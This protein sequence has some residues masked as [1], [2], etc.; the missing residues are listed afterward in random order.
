MRFWIWLIL[1]LPCTL[2]FSEENEEL[3][4]SS[5]EQIAGFSLDTNTLVSPLTGQLS[6]AETDLIARGAQNVALRRVY[7]PPHLPSPIGDRPV[8]EEYL[9]AKYILK[10]YKGW[11][12]APHAR[13][14]FFPENHVVRLTDP[15]GITLDFSVKDSET[16]ILSP[17]FGMSNLSGDRPGGEYDLRNTQITFA[18]NKRKIV[19]R[20]PDGIIR[21]YQC[22]AKVFSKLVYSLEKE[23]L[24]H[25]KLLRYHYKNGYL[26]QVASMDVE[27]RH[28]YAS[29]DLD[30][31]DS[32]INF[33]T[34][35]GQTAFYRYDIKK[36]KI[37]I[38][39][40]REGVKATKILPPLLTKV[41]SPFY[42]NEGI[43][44]SSK[45][46]LEEM[47]GKEHIFQCTHK[48]FQA[49]KIPSHL[50]I[51]QLKL[52]TG[53]D[54]T[55][56]KVYE[57]DYDLPRPG[58][59]AGMT[60][61]KNSDGRET[62]YHF[63][64]DLF[65]ERVEHK[66]KEGK[67]EKEKIYHFRDTPDHWLDFLAIRNQTG[68]CVY[69]KHFT[70]DEFGNPYTESFIGDLEGA[71][72]E[73]N[74][75]I[76][77]H[78]SK[79]GM[80]LLLKEDHED[81]RSYYYDY[82]PG[83]N[84]V[85]A[86]LLLVQEKIYTRE[87]YE[88]DDCNNLIKTIR[89]DGSSLDKN[90]LTD[91]TERLIT[92][93]TLKQEPPFLHLPEWIE[94]R[95]LNGMLKKTHL[96]YD[97]HG[98]VSQKDIYDAN[99]EFAYSLKFTYNERGD[100]MTQPN[101]LGDW[102][103]FN[104][105][106]RGRKEFESSF[107]GRLIKTTTHDLKGRVREVKETG[108]TIARTTT[109]EHDPY[110]NLIKKEDPFGN[111]TK[112]TPDSAAKKPARI[113]HPSISS[114][115]VTE[116]FTYDTFGRE[117]S[118][119]DPRGHTITTR[120]NFYD[121]PTHIQYPDGSSESFR[122]YKNGKLKS[123]EDR[124]GL[125]I[126]YT[127]DPLWRVETKTFLSKEKKEIAKET[128][129]YSSFHL[130]TFTDKEGHVT[131][132]EYDTAGRKI[133][134]TTEERITTFH[135]DSLGRVSEIHADPLITHLAYDFCNQVIEKKETDLKGNLLYKI[136]YSYDKDGNLETDTCYVHN[137]KSIEV[138]LYDP[139]GREIEHRDPLGFTAKTTYNEKESQLQITKTDPRGFATIKTYDAHNN[140][141]E[142]K[143]PLGVTELSYDPCSNLL[144]R[145]DQPQDGAAQTIRYTYTPTNQVET[146]TRAAGTEH[147]RITSYTYTPSGKV[148]T[149]TLPSGIVLRFDY[150]PLGFLKE[151]TS[152]DKTIHHTFTYNRLGDLLE[153][154]DHINSI[155]VERTPDPFGNILLENFSTG[156]SL[157][158]TYDRFNRP[159]TL[160]LGTG[161][162][163]RY[164][165][166]PKHLR[167]IERFSSS[168]EL[169]YTHVYEEYD[170]A[171]NIIQEDLIGSLGKRVYKYDPA[172]RT[173]KLIS[174]YFSQEFSYDE[175]GNPKEI[176]KNGILHEY[177]YDALS[178]ISSEPNH[179][180]HHNALY[181]R[182]EK[183]GEEIAI[184]PLNELE[185]YSY[186]LDGNMTTKGDLTFSY[187]ALNRLKMVHCDDLTITFFYDPLGRRLIK[188]LS[189]RS[190]GEKHPVETEHYLYDGE[191]E[192]GAFT[193]DHRQKNL[194]ISTIAIELEEKPFAP[195]LDAHNNI[196]G[197]IDPATQTIAATYTFTTFGEKLLTDELIFN[198]W[199]YASKR[200]DPETGLI[201]FGKRYYD[202][203]LARW[204]TIDPAG[205]ID[206]V[207]FYQYVYNNPF[208]YTD[209]NGEFAIPLFIWAIGTSLPS[210]SAIITPIIYGA[211]TGAVL[212]TGYK[213]VDYAN[214]HDANYSPA[215][216]YADFIRKSELADEKKGKKSEG[217]PKSNVDQNKQ[218]KDAKKEIERNLERQLIKDEERRFHDHVTGQ[219]YNY[220]EL[221]EEEYWLFNEQ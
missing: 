140:L 7:I 214:S 53:E 83:T 73:E 142:K 200:L 8:W 138:F 163:V 203:A 19:V 66:N 57:F 145:T 202:P 22:I 116:Q 96:H 77:R 82:V 10:N 133:Q 157:K 159:L 92:T 151:L 211:V 178:Q 48:E 74:Y 173:L 180:Y 124:E 171:G 106:A 172:G 150:F 209:P 168:G 2:L 193:T 24:P 217:P 47:L 69:K 72:V 95:H 114:L 62:L 155:S 35:A 165:Y 30:Y 201:Y 177:T 143:T 68:E 87:F 175:A 174:P 167:Q 194:K 192:I 197:L 59:K 221:V 88:Y 219:G 139:T 105:D 18:D 55:F 125:T 189:K 170:L 40:K 164:T 109:Y 41:S 153:A 148:S 130:K 212:W 90:I 117:S 51:W 21:H 37:D 99:G 137:E 216:D 126:L 61:V 146:L 54:D 195:I 76:W 67:V 199:R 85:T 162:S 110:D 1:S 120:Y 12:F 33:T 112:Y 49:H 71:G 94:E 118:S 152:S 218:A 188:S 63:S 14:Y 215:K 52:P 32:Q 182:T 220:H 27:E 176:L 122:Y 158:K 25:G 156:L 135:Y 127:Y 132:Y 208:R 134:E 190:W 86:K 20:A 141:I 65:L 108:K 131:S 183:N 36:I 204:I 97:D 101:P 26:S 191:E 4:P 34:S 111:I 84:L 46:L 43:R 149:K 119:T 91:V 70:Y 198:P 45:H 184:N 103:C 206:S 107:S 11:R 44:Y 123:H 129:I 128:F 42:R 121:S 160:E 50:R 56:E 79:D 28:V 29:I 60:R 16:K 100:L 39:E 136:E 179:H 187:D 115:P 104:Y 213:T 81:G 98:N 166:D 161:D 207:N 15:N 9:F 5:S 13:A 78:Y 196:C 64:Q 31:E 6:I 23:I 113:E 58:K 144:E 210:L 75:I 80:H 102:K 185:S 169:L 154:T 186:D 147:E 89:D 205:F 93:Y 17:T 3:F 38:K 181:N